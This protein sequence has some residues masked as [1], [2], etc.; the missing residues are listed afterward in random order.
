MERG[1]GRAAGHGV[2]PP[3]VETQRSRRRRESQRE[4]ETDGGHGL[5]ADKSK[6]ASHQPRCVRCAESCLSDNG[7]IATGRRAG[8]EDTAAP[9]FPAWPTA[10]SAHRIHACMDAMDVSGVLSIC[11]AHGVED[12][13]RKVAASRMHERSTDLAG[14]LRRAQGSHVP[15]SEDRLLRVPHYHSPVK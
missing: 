3:A 13:R 11:S 8:R 15:S 12:K 9:G 14:A 2:G 4:R 5:Q 6:L 10:S 1:G 7:Y